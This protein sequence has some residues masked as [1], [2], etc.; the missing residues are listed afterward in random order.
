MIQRLIEKIT[1]NSAKRPRQDKCRPEQHGFGNLCPE[2]ASCHDDKKQAEKDSRSA[3][4]K[5]CAIG[6]PVSKGSAEGLRK[7]DRD[8]VKNFDSGSADGIDRYRPQ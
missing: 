6:S 2:M 8:P 3:V 5:V 1:D 4:A 7:H